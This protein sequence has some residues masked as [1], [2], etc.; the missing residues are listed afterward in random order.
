MDSPLTLSTFKYNVP[1]IFIAHEV[2]LYLIFICIAALNR[3][4]KIKK[5]MISQWYDISISYNSF[6]EKINRSFATM[7]ARF[8]ATTWR[9]FINLTNVT[10]TRY[11]QFAKF[12]TYHLRDNITIA[13]RYVCETHAICYRHIFF[14]TIIDY[15]GNLDR[16]LQTAWCIT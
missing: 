15:V 7:V 5:I 10:I 6:L 1:P 16:N 11:S 2:S 13:K 4:V 3:W 9:T 14:S 8:F 12:N